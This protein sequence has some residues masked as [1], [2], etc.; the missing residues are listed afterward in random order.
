M[1]QTVNLHTFRDAFHRAD[2]GDQFSWAGLAVIFEYL[3]DLEAGTGEE[4][5]LDPVAICGD[6]AESTPEE[7][8]LDHN[9][10]VGDVIDFLENHGAFIGK[11][12]DGA[13]IYAQV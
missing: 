9:I 13:I 12:D 6:F 7:I 5:E 8:A 1:K 3:E 11:T 4:I 2:R 10:K